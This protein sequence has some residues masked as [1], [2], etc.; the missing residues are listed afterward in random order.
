MVKKDEMMTAPTVN[1]KTPHSS[2]ILYSKFC[3]HFS[4]NQLVIGM[5]NKEAIIT[6]FIKSSERIFNKLH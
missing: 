3:N 4:M 6:N 5:P 2:D 1:K